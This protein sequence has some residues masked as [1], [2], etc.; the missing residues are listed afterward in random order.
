MSKP[1][2]AVDLDDV[3]ADSAI[4]FVEYGNKKWGTN[5]TI[6]SYDEDWST[7]WQMDHQTLREMSNHWHTTGQNL[8]HRPKTDALDAL[9]RLRDRFSLIILTSRRIESQKDTIEWINLHFKGVFDD[10]VFCGIWDKMHKHNNKIT[11]AEMCL[12]IKAYYLIDDQPK[13]IIGCTSA[14][15]KCIMFGN[16][17]WNRDIALP[18]GAIRAVNWQEVLEYFDAV[19]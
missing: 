3:L 14:G 18:D 19:K 11:K 13:H 6:E 5:L 2:I 10:I 7:M 12:R 4:D 9:T 16:Y 8:K 1:I 17:P 15:I